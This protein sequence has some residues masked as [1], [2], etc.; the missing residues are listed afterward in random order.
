MQ[1]V[2]QWTESSPEQDSTSVDAPVSGAM[3]DDELSAYGLQK[4][5]AFVR[6]EP[7][8]GARR[9]RRA[10]EKSGAEGIR[11]V[12]LRLPEPVHAAM[13]QLARD[14][15]QGVS[16]ADALR[17]A[18]DNEAGPL[19]ASEVAKPCAFLEATGRPV[20]VS[21]MQQGAPFADALQPTPRSEPGLIAES[22]P[23]Q[24]RVRRETTGQAAALKGW[25]LLIARWLGL[26]GA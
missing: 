10:R 18:L 4:T 20:S 22:G 1:N 13:K 8:A 24:P 21:G 2:N 14:M 6:R 17:H 3:S 26:A 11:Q 15:Q 7:S 12:N 19:A 9:S 25:R 5:T 16:F 23:T